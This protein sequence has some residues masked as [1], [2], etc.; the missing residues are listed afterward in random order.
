MGEISLRVTE[1]IEPN[2]I[3]LSADK[4][5]VPF[6]VTIHLEDAGEKTT[7]G[8]AIIDVDIPIFLKPMIQGPLNQACQKFSDLLKVIPYDQ[9]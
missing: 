5:P 4:S 6:S 8:H 3:V 7:K 9:I 1:R 2:K